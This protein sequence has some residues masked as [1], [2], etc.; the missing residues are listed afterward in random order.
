MDLKKIPET[1]AQEDQPA[2]VPI[3][4][5][6]GK[7]PDT[8]SDGSPT[9]ISIVGA[10]SSI[11]R[12]REAA[13]QAAQAETATEVTRDA[14]RVESVAWSVVDWHGIESDGA[15]LDCTP[16]NVR[17][18]LAQAPWVCDRLVIAFNNRR[19]FFTV[20]SSAS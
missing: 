3:M 9:T 14:F 19:R 13:W 6:D 12:E 4:Q 11:Y 1:V 20:A 16:E 15:P 18:V 10:Y 5:P 8:A 17:A 7:T 2:V